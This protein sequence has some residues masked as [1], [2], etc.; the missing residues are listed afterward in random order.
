MPRDGDASL[1][2]NYRADSVEL[3]RR[4]LVETND[5]NNGAAGRYNLLNV[6]AVACEE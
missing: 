5:E 2:R 6:Y 4:S 3:K 1:S